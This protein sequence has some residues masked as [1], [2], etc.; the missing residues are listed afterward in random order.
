MVSLPATIDTGAEHGFA[1]IEVAHE[2]A[3]LAHQQDAGR[4]VPRRQVALPVGVDATG[5]DP[6]EIERRRAEAAQSGDLLL[7]HLELLAE[8]REIAAAAV[9]QSAGKHRIAMRLRA[10][11]RMRRSLRKAPLPRSAVKS[12]SVAGL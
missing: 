10:A 7:D 3:G 11:T 1:A 12:S 5:R 4:H 6:G 8:Q 9:R 2:S